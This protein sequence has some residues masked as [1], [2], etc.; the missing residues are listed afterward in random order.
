MHTGGACS[1]AAGRTRRASEDLSDVEGLRQ[2]ALHLA[3]A[4]HRLF[5]LLRKLVHAQ[6][7]NDVLQILVV[8]RAQRGT[9]VV[10]TSAVTIQG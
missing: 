10:S 6:D 5:V 9:A 8:L 1:P 4:R 3:G 7:G 2:E